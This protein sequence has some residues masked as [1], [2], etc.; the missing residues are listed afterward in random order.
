MAKHES[1]LERERATFHTMGFVDGL[2]CTKEI[3]I[4]NL[5]QAIENGTIVVTKGK[6]E[7]FDIIE[8]VGK[9]EK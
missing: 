6:Q 9:V 1:R 4:T 3:I 8:S 5:Q 7:L 2:T